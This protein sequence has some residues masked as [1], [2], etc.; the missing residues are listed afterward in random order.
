MWAPCLSY[1]IAKWEIFK[2]AW[3]SCALKL[4][5]LHSRIQLIIVLEALKMLDLLVTKFNT[6]LAIY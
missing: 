1:G 4:R 6:K 5:G 3:V 2:L